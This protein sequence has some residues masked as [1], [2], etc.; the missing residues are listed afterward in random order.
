MLLWALDKAARHAC[1]HVVA[2]ASSPFQ[3]PKEVFEKGPL[4]QTA[5]RQ[6]RAFDNLMYAYRYTYIEIQI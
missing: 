5:K 6:K 3:S 4:V 2:H 1:Q